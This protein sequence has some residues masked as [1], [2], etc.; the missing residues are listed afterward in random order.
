MPKGGD[1]KLRL[2]CVCGQKMKVSRSHYGLPGKCIACRQKIRLPREDELEEG[3]TEIYL[4]DHPQLLRKMKPK[5]DM[6]QE[7]EAAQAALHS[8]PKPAVTVEGD[9]TPITELD[10]AESKQASDE[11]VAGSRPL[12][13]LDSVRTLAS[14]ELGYER[15]IE[16]LE[17]QSSRDDAKIAETKGKLARTR[18]ARK[19]LN[20]QIRQRLMEVAIELTNAQDKI[21]QTQI[22]A[23]VGEEPFEQFQ[24]KMH[25]LRSRRDRLERRQINLRG[26]IA[27]TSPFEVGGPVECTIADIPKNGFT[28]NIAE[29]RDDDLALLQ[30]HARELKTAFHFRSMAERRGAEIKKTV[31]DSADG[32]GQGLLDARETNRAERKRARAQ[33]MFHQ[34]R[35]EQL[36]KDYKND[37]E[38]LETYLE[39]ARDRMST[40]RM[41]RQ[42]YDKLEQKA[43]KYKADLTKGISLATRLA[44]ANAFEDVPSTKG[45]FLKRLGSGGDS[46]ANA[47]AARG[48]LWMAG[49]LWLVS[50]ILPVAG[51]T[52]LAGAV[53]NFSGASGNAGLVLALPIIAAIATLGVSFVVNPML[54]GTALAALWG[55]SAI[56]MA[57]LINEA[58]FS[59]DLLANRFR[60]GGGW[61]GRPGMVTLILANV[62]VLVGAAQS[63]S[64]SASAIRVLGAAVVLVL[65]A[66]GWLGTNGIDSYL[67]V[68]KLELAMDTFSDAT[69]K[70]SGTV[71]VVNSGTR[72][73]HLV[74]R[75][76]DA[77]NGYLYGFEKKLGT[78]SFSAVTPEGDPMGLENVYPHITIAPGESAV[79]AFELPAGDYRMALTPRDAEA[80]VEQ[81]IVVADRRGDMNLL[82][83][84]DEE[85]FITLDEDPA[86]PAPR[87]QPTVSEE[88]VDDESMEEPLVVAEA[89]AAYPAAV[90]DGIITGPEGDPRFMMRLL[91]FEGDV[92]QQQRYLLDS[93]VHD[94]WTITEYDSGQNAVTVQKERT[95]LVIRRGEQVALKERS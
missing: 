45:T 82:P 40:N 73:M 2:Y 29:S 90:L 86:P 95:M 30:H 15:K 60:S 12:D 22:S 23:R 18:D 33:V 35:L 32:P 54:R 62:L 65:A 11:A 56:G 7:T 69:R 9:P 91:L 10:L 80:Q 93:E 38:T 57:Y 59:L 20:E 37:L 74:S 16:T 94:G 78:T 4:K 53:M 83:A 19:D 41:T 71:R 92:P 50:V 34:Q 14:L 64:R 58:H 3:M 47:P 13:L 6:E 79:I 24:E 81:S 25:R 1:D 68:P 39:N 84:G 31:E 42:E 88:P 26:W 75:K 28:F 46:E 17:A 5:R 43:R 52:S 36:A 63:F 77:R 44:H 66:V 27:A 72:E 67:P 55:V 49:A 85:V 89:E 87:V 8:V 76:T 48:I 61:L 21:S 51:D 70:Q